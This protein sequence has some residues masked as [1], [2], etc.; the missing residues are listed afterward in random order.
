MANFSVSAEVYINLYEVLKHT[1]TVERE[2]W[3]L[4]TLTSGSMQSVNCTDLVRYGTAALLSYKYCYYSI[5]FFYECLFK[6]SRLFK[7]SPSP[8]KFNENTLINQSF[9]FPETCMSEGPEL[10]PFSSD[11]SKPVAEAV[12]PERKQAEH[13]PV[14]CPNCAHGQLHPMQPI[15]CNPPSMFRSKPDMKKILF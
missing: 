10:L 8:I 2:F 11:E 12:A 15:P 7:T 14:V 5:S 4:P 1:S 6:T 13:A 3:L 9:I